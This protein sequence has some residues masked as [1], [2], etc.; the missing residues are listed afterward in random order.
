VSKAIATLVKTKPEW[1]TIETNSGCAMTVTTAGVHTSG[2]PL[3]R[4]RLLIQEEEW[5]RGILAREVEARLLPRNCIQRHMNTDGSFCIGFEAPRLVV[6]EAG[7]NR[8]WS[9]LLGYLRCQ[10]VATTTRRWPP[11][12]GLSHGEAASA[13][14]E[15]EVLA[16]ELGLL[17]QYREHVEYGTDWPPTDVLPSEKLSK[18]LELEEKRQR[19]DH[20]FLHFID[21]SCCGTMDDCPIA[22][23][24]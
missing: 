2:E 15:A 23:S 24:N 11:N 3:R 4:Y 8:W 19:L 10:D 1:V 14:I 21:Y 16:D 13:Q 5:V 18:L 20:D 6:D 22:E 9:L 17:V 12:R 7:G